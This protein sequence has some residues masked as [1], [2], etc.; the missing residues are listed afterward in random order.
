MSRCHRNKIS[1]SQRSRGPVNMA[2]KKNEKNGLYNFGVYEC[3]REQNGSPYF[4][5]IVRQCKWPSLSR[6]IV[7]IQKFC[8]HVNLMSPFLLY[9]PYLGYA[10]A[11]V[12]VVANCIMGLFWGT[13]FDP[14]SRSTS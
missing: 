6:K 13:N 11:W 8:Y 2:E 1:R 9:G 7:E 5:S 14:V 4:C 3:T 10:W 12:C